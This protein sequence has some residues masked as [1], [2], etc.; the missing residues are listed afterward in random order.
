MAMLLAQLKAAEK[1][2]VDCDAAMERQRAAMEEER[3][4]WARQQGEAV[5]RA[6]KEAEERAAKE[7][8]QVHKAW[9][10]ERAGMEKKIQDMQ[11][12]LR[13]SLCDASEMLIR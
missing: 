4:A 12:Q 2:R 11:D 1:Y 8:E 13:V 3:T 9:E 10:Q 5:E 7:K 6:A